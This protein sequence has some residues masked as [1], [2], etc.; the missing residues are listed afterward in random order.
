[1]R[2]AARTTFDPAASPGKIWQVI[3]RKMVAEGQHRI[4]SGPA[5]RAQTIEGGRG[6]ARGDP[7][8]NCGVIA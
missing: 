3:V 2:C 5:Q 4:F 6:V 7:H 1:M 8:K